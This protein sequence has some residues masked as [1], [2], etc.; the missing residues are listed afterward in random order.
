MPT[1]LTTENSNKYAD[2]AYPNK[3]KQKNADDYPNKSKHK[4]NTLGAFGTNQKK[5][6]RK[7]G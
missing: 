7:H 5:I 1:F 3:S 4:K 6:K 2:G